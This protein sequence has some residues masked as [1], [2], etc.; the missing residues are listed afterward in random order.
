[1]MTKEVSTTIV[2]FMTPAAGILCNWYGMAI[3]TFSENALFLTTGPILF[4][5]NM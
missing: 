4:K 5:F 1:M 3:K 2:N